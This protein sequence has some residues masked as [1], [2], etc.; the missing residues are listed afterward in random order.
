M[1][2]YPWLRIAQTDPTLSVRQLRIASGDRTALVPTHI[3]TGQWS[4]LMQHYDAHFAGLAQLL[5]RPAATFLPALFVG[6]VGGYANGLTSLRDLAD[7]PRATSE[8]LRSCQIIASQA[9]VGSI[10]V[11]YST[12]TAADFLVE[13]APSALTLI[14]AEPYSYMTL[15]WGTVDQYL[16][17]LPKKRRWTA[18]KEIASLS[19]CGYTTKDGSLAQAADQI[20]PMLAELQARHGLPGTSSDIAEQLHQLA[21]A[22]GDHAA[23]VLIHSAGQPVGFCILIESGSSLH[24]YKVG[25]E[26]PP[27]K[28]CSVY[29]NALIYL[30]LQVAIER[31]LSR[32]ELGITT[33]NAK[34]LRGADIEARWFI[35]VGE[36]IPGEVS[37][38]WNQLHYRKLGALLAK[39]G[40][41]MTQLDGRVFRRALELRS[42]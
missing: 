3:W 2:E 10:S 24:V 9:R 23:V 41:T 29:F 18:R 11:P 1:D 27:A 31:K 25:F 21:D 22:A 37:R 6:S 39:H 40:K 19:R 35:V 26:Y 28:E 12:S 34:V 5:R 14:A 4:M 20:A 30:P 32:L 33:A 8:L 36:Q 7:G 42:G 38:A 15:R 13:N 17:D 16:Q